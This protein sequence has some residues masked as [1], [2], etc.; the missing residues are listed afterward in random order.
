MTFLFITKFSILYCGNRLINNDRNY[1]ILNIKT[2]I[3]L[4]I[5]IYNNLCYISVKYST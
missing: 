2:L 3:H 1:F 5:F 4:S